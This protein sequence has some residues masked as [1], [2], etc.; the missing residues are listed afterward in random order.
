MIVFPFVRH[1]AIFASLFELH[2]RGHSLKNQHSFRWQNNR[3]RFQIGK[4]EICGFSLY[5][6]WSLSRVP[7]VKIFWKWSNQSCWYAFM[8]IDMFE[9]GHWK[10]YVSNLS[11]H[12]I[13]LWITYWFRVVFLFFF[14]LQLLPLQGAGRERR[15]SLKVTEHRP[16]RDLLFGCTPYY[17]TFCSQKYQLHTLFK[18][19]QILS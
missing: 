3:L 12:F 7:L 17:S 2:K 8:Y 11:W 1:F 4:L 6:K 15:H 10:Y 5:L 9:C 18:C 16:F 13:F 19:F 14:K